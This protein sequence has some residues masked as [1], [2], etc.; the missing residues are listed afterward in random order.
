MSE[1]TPGNSATNQ[2][3]SDPDEQALAAQRARRKK[4]DR[5]TLAIIVAMIVVWAAGLFYR[6]E[7]RAVYRSWRLTRAQSEPARDRWAG[8]L[9]SL[10]EP[11]LRPALRLTR[12][13]DA[14]VRQAGVRVICQVVQDRLDSSA[15]SVKPRLRELL[16]DPD[17]GVQLEAITGV[18]LTRDFESLDAL[19][20]LALGSPEALVACRATSA[21]AGLGPLEQSVPLLKQILRKAD[22][23]SVRAQAIDS[24]RGEP[25][26]FGDLT[27]LVDALSD[28]RPVVVK[29]TSEQIAPEIWA[30]LQR[31]LDGIG[32]PQEPAAS[33]PALTRPATKTVADYAVEE[34]QRRTTKAFGFD[35]RDPEPERQA[36][37]E[38]W[39]QFVTGGPS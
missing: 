17:A 9:A 4:W 8:Y 26:A 33:A 25:L 31:E 2:T 27:L 15:D 14:K 22:D 7:L 24:L 5:I 29:P 6:N 35:A 13:D 34:L 32:P 28:V 38:R 21:L 12:N 10:G 37:I 30:A 19:A 3:S 39:R 23:P 1:Q 20:R 16:N 18:L 11:A 36:A